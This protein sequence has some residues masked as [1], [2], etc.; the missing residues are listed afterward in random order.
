MSARV[1]PGKS[2]AHQ[3]T[4]HS[5]PL[6]TPFAKERVSRLIGSVEEEGG[7]IHLDGRSI[8]IPGYE[9]GNFV[10]PTVL[11]GNTTMEAYK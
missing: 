9:K 5:G 1:A 4:Q 11:E 8:I 3:R 10:G 2:T 7:T 6:I